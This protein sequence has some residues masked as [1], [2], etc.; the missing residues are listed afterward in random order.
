M[1][2]WLLLLALSTVLLPGQSA[3][4]PSPVPVERKSA[5]KGDNKGPRCQAHTKEGKQC[6][7]KAAPGSQFCWQ[8]SGKKKPS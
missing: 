7:R 2:R 6:S 3:G 8:H 4:L 5:A 1:I